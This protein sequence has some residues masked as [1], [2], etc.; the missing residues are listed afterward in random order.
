MLRSYVIDFKSSWYDHL[1]LI[2]FS[3]NNNYHSNIQK[4]PFE[5]SYRRRCRSLIGW[6]EVG[7]AALIEQNLVYEKM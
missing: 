3:Y 6:F 7:E 2:E 4:A 5:A 1:H